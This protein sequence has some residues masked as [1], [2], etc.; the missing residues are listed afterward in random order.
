MYSQWAH[1][2]ECAETLATFQFII[3]II[4]MSKNI[5]CLQNISLFFCTSFFFPMKGWKLQILVSKSSLWLY[6]TGSDKL[7]CKRKQ[8]DNQLMQWRQSHKCNVHFTKLFGM[9]IWS[10]IKC[11][12]VNTVNF[13][14]WKS[15]TC[16]NFFTSWFWLPINKNNQ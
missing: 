9:C 15:L 16:T 1:I 3:K 12:S 10:C 8:N 5:H 14:E 4:V 11:Y 2:S 13:W 6:S 7:F